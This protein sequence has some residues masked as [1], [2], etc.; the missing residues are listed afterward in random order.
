MLWARLL[1]Y[2]SEGSVVAKYLAAKGVTAFVLKYRLAHTGEDATQEFST[3]IAD[4]QKF[5]EIIGK[6]I[7]QS[8]ADGLAAV[9]YVRQHASE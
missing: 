1:A 2:A 3:L 4:R 6:V 5:G 7:P 8:N 9:T